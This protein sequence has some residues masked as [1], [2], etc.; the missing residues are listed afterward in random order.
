MV[1]IHPEQMSNLSRFCDSDCRPLE[2]T[3]RELISLSKNEA[4]ILW[5]PQF[6]Q[7]ISRYHGQEALC[8][9]RHPV[10]MHIAPR[11]SVRKIVY[12][13]TELNTGLTVRSFL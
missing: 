7:C 8:E 2:Q 4:M 11:M 13:G 3:W 12:F 1:N 6:K 5:L 10:H 9:M